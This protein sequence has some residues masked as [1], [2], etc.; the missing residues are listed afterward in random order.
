SPALLVAGV[1]VVALAAFFLSRGGDD[2][3]EHAAP[4][5]AS[6]AAVSAPPV[7]ALP[8]APDIPRQPLNVVAP[9]PAPAEEAPEPA[10]PP[11]AEEADAMLLG[12][13]Q[14]A[15]LQPQ[16]LA[17]LNVAH[18]LDV[19]VAMVDWLAQGVVPR[20]L[21]AVPALP[22]FP[23]TENDD[24]QL[25]MGDAAYARYDGLARAVAAA[26]TAALAAGFHKLRSL[27]EGAYG[28]LG[29]DE[30][31]FDNALIRALDQVLA[32]PEI[33]GPILLARKS[34]MYTYA[35]PGLEQL[36]DVQKQL[37]RMGPD[38]LRVIK[39]Q[40]RTL[41]QQLLAE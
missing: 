12:T 11:T 18:P 6:S 7:A 15:S 20:K 25:V 1:V 40:A 28:K 35:D 41:R 16:L 5:A 32:T 37:L 27:L 22:A 33:A 29:L 34:V 13:L 8:P 39:E 2:A 30:D 10:P 31:K 26:D 4:D 9:S 19:S 17:L 3:D 21:L 24:G 38:N 14:A 23:V 36:P